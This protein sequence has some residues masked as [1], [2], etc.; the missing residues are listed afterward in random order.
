MSGV[1]EPHVIGLGRIAGLGLSVGREGGERPPRLTQ[2]RGGERHELPVDTVQ[3]QCLAGGDVRDLARGQHPGALR[4]IRL[5]VASE[6]L[7]AA[8]KDVREPELLACI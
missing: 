3:M 2:V 4:R 1:G 7:A 5:G 8:P 6:R